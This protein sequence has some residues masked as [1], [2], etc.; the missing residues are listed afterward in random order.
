MAN[1][2]DHYFADEAREQLDQLEHLLTL[3]EAPDPERLLNL[4]SSV[5]SSAQRAGTETVASVAE[6]LEDAA[7]S[8]LTASIAWSDEIRSLAVQT[9]SDLKLLLRALNR[10]GPEEERRVRTAI[11]RWDEHDAGAE[12]DPVPIESL[13][14]D[15]EGPHVIGGPAPIPE[16]AVVEIETLLLSGS[17]A[18]AAAAELRPEFDSI[19]RGDAVPE[20]PLAE[21][22]E[23]LF[24]LIEQ[25]RES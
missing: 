19:A 8:I 21:L 14:Y 11:E 24:V 4:A 2:V 3:P 10:W 20:R 23:E 1:G 16:D 22:V 12:P 9:V 18:L 5:R 25:A 7:R 13:Y 6:R 15:D 17:A